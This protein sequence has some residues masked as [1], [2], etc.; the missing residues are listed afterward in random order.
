MSSLQ[1]EKVITAKLSAKPTHL[2]SFESEFLGLINFG[3]INASPPRAK[4]VER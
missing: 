2:Q 1:G 4:V 3:V